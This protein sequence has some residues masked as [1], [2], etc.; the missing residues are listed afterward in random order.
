MTWIGIQHVADCLA[1]KPPGQKWTSS[2]LDGSAMAGADLAVG[3][4]QSTRVR[5]DAMV[6]AD[7]VPGERLTTGG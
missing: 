5:I 2:I 3:F 7:R 4:A 1:S 6:D